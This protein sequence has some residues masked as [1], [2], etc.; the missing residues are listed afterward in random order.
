MVDRRVRLGIMLRILVI[1][2][3]TIGLG[4][5]RSVA[6]AEEP[7]AG[8]APASEEPAIEI[9]PTEAAAPAPGEA[10][11]PAPGEAAA[12]APGEAAAPAAPAP[13]TDE[14]DDAMAEASQ[15]A[16]L[17][18]DPARLREL[19]ESARQRAAERILAKLEAKQAAQVD[20]VATLIAWFS[21][22][23]LL[24]VFAPLGLRKRYPQKTGLLLKYGALA[25]VTF[26]VTVNL[27]AVSLQLV[28]GVQGALGAV[29]NPQLAIIDGAID[30]LVDNADEIAGIGGIIEPALTN[31]ESGVEDSPAVA[32]AV[33]LGGNLA[34]LGKD[35]SALGGLASFFKQLSGLLGG[36]PILLSILAV[37]IFVL[38]F[39]P[40][41][42]AIVTMPAQVAEGRATGR[43][44][45][46]QVLGTVGREFVVTLAF[47]VVL[48]L[49][50]IFAGATLGV[51][52]RPAIEALIGFVLGA[53]AYLM[54]AASPSSVTLLIS[55]AAVGVFLALNVAVV[56]MST[57]FYLG[58]AHKI[59]RARLHDRVPL[60]SHKRFFGWGTLALLWAQLLP[61]VFIAGAEKA[62]EKI[63]D[64]FG[65]EDELL[66][67]MV[68]AGLTLTVG[69][70]VVF[71]AARGVRAL[72]FLARYPVSAKPAAP[73]QPRLPA[74][75][76]HSEAQVA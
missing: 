62:V 3:L 55:L 68:A 37:V 35:V 75:A 30:T 64:R 6:G 13:Q 31:M 27:F 74:K 33:A 25:A 34:A 4:R 29:V 10:A 21:L 12:P 32:M 63:F 11:A 45:V 23:G 15:A 43:Q 49:V 2:G 18:M 70:I 59:L 54:T 58:K 73:A 67:A 7:V 76:A 8:A 46:R 48:V 66:T 51:V 24:L 72:A 71:W 61:L 53:F 40:T 41:L 56:L 16:G 19:L 22:A 57:A 28:R 26:L 20:R 5:P 50:T 36:L 14:G 1:V 60:R 52:V 42:M 47:I 44:V 65:G 39:R 17:A 9:T 38:A 69:F